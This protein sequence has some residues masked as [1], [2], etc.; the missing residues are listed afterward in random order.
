[1]LILAASRAVGG[2][3]RI[4]AWSGTGVR[5]SYTQYAP[6]GYPPVF[7]VGA[8]TFLLPHFDISYDIQRALPGAMAVIRPSYW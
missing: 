7:A 2:A 5:A 4:R 8:L 6:R 1:M 3:E